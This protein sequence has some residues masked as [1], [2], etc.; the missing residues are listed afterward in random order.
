MIGAVVLAAGAARR[1]GGP[2]QVLEHRG[3]P[4]VRRTAQAALDAGCAPVVV[5]VG[6]HAAETRDAIA[7]LPVEIVVN[8]AW[9]EGLG[10]SIRCGVEVIAR[11]SHVEGVLLLLSDQPAID[12]KLIERVLAGGVRTTAC[13]YAGTV[14]PPALF[15]RSCFDRL[16]VLSGDRGAKSVLLDEPEIARIDWPQGALDVDAPVDR[17]GN[18]HAL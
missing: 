10:A 3:V 2:K 6:A 1:Y 9:E 16:L 13:A 14:G 17:P 7:S 18:D 12:A 5:V 8:A 4:L 11:A 15:P